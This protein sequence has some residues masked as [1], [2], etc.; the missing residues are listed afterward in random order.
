MKEVSLWGKVVVVGD[1]A[2]K[3]R[4]DISFRFNYLLF[5]RQEA[6]VT[7]R[8]SSITFPCNLRAAPRKCVCES[9]A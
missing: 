7:T 3:P 9:N 2:A 5:F 4:S 1:S 6:E 8:G